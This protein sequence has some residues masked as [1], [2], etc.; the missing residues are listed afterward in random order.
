MSFGFN[1]CKLISCT[2]D[3]MSLVKTVFTDSNFDET[4]FHHCQMREANFENS[5]FYNSRFQECK[6]EK[7]RFVGV[8]GLQLDIRQNNI[9]K[10]V[11]DTRAAMSLLDPLGI[12]IV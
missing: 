5:E 10:A 12:T 11:F 2:F 8:E 3:D 4:M 9:S 1:V 7:A 6:L